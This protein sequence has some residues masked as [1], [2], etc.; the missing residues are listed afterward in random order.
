M[1]DDIIE[2]PHGMDFIFLTACTRADNLAFRHSCVGQMQGADAVM[3]AVGAATCIL[4]QSQ[5]QSILLET[6]DAV[7]VSAAVLLPGACCWLVAVTAVPQCAS[8]TEQQITLLGCAVP[9]CAVLRCAVLYCD[10]LCCDGLHCGIMV[11]MTLH[12]C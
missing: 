3:S 1:P 7:Q 8:V 9:C 5:Q 12:S 6:I 4:P 11:Q 10:V 2:T